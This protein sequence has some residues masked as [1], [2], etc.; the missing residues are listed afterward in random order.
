MSKS[1]K[2]KLAPRVSIPSKEKPNSP[3][4]EYD[5]ISQGKKSKSWPLKSKR[6]SK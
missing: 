4:R 2:S 5:K 1:G 3:F 6:L